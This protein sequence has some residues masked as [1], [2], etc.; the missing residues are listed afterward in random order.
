M[1]KRLILLT[2]LTVL[3]ATSCTKET[4]QDQTKIQPDPETSTARKA[5]TESTFTTYTIA[6]G[7]HYSSP[8]T[9]KTVSG[10]TMSF[11][12]K[13]DSSCIY[14]SVNPANQ[15]D[16]NK[17][18]GFNEG[19]FSTN[20]SARVGWN[21]KNDTLWLYPYSH[22]N[23]VNLGAQN[24][25]GYPVQ[26]GAEIPCSITV[27]GNTYIYSINGNTVT[28]PRGPSSS[29]FSGYQQYPYF[30]GDETAPHKITIQVKPL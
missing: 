12:A 21:W 2:A 27:S 4:L 14:T 19:L 25:T 16:I 6:A 17:L 1:K 10:T 15:W 24:P 29:T 23:G 11:V 22:V 28:T 13:F 30:G 8:N 3:L 20:N 9:F 7:A 18:W 26:I 5:A